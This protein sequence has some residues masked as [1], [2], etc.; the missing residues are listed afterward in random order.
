MLYNIFNGP[1]S[2]RNGCL[3]H[4]I[5]SP[6]GLMGLAW[7]HGERTGQALPCEYDNILYAPSAMLLCKGGKWGGV[8]ISESRLSREDTL[9]LSWIAQC[10]YDAYETLEWD[11]LFMKPGK[12]LFHSFQAGTSWSFETVSV[13]GPGD[14]YLLGE[15]CNRL[16]LIDRELG[17]PIWED[18]LDSPHYRLGTPCLAYMGM[19]SGLP[20]FYDATNCGCLVPQYGSRGGNLV[21]REDLGALVCPVVV[22]GANIVEIVERKG[23]IGAV[24]PLCHSEWVLNIDRAL[25]DQGSS[26]KVSVSLCIDYDDGRN[27]R[28]FHIADFKPGDIPDVGWGL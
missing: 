23:K 9:E 25:A 14:C 26:S 17:E 24:S 5:S 6:S 28:M 18:T 16:V 8:S 13:Y 2:R 12:T 4:P 11:L 22:N 21:W 3:L 1:G 10:E 20:F 19:Q 15:S 27:R 7:S